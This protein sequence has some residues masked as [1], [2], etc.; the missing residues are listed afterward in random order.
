MGM[1]VLA[2]CLAG[3][4][5]AMADAVVDT[6]AEPLSNA[7]APADIPPGLQIPALPDPD[8]GEIRAALEQERPTAAPPEG[9]T[10]VVVPHH[11]LAAD[12][13]ARG[14][15]AASG[16][17]YDR[18][19][20]LAPDHFG[21][22]ASGAATVTGCMDTVLGPV[23]FDDLAQALI[24]TAAEIHRHP[25]L[26]LEHGV[27]SLLPFLAEL[28]PGTPVLPVVTSMR[29]GE[30][31]WRAI[32]DHLGPVVTARTLIVQ[33][34]DF[35]HFLS[36]TEAARV[37]RENL[38]ALA[39]GDWRAMAALDQPRHLDAMG[40]QVIMQ[41]LQAEVFQ[42][43]SAVLAN[44]TSV[45]YGGDADTVTTYIV[46]AFHP[47]PKALSAL[48]YADQSV[49]YVAGDMHLGRFMLPV[50]QSPE[51]M[52][53]VLNAA[54]AHS[55]GGPV[56]A[57]LE[58]VLAAEHIVNAPPRAHVM[59]A[60]LALPV[61]RNL[62]VVALSHA[63]NH[64][65][66]LAQDGAAMTQDLMAERGTPLIGHGEVADLGALRVLALN[67][68]PHQG[69]YVTDPQGAAPCEVEADPPLIAFVH[70]G[71]EY[72]NVPA[73]AEREMADAF[74]RCGFSAVIGAHSH[75][76]SERVELSLGQMPWVFSLGNFVFDQRA[77]RAS[78]AM[79]ELRI[80][81]RG[82]VAMRLVPIPNLFE[83]GAHQY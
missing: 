32:A 56:L 2:V 73:A 29:A 16:G 38:A 35:G 13:M 50:L 20:L 83:L 8:A 62:N 77:D 57:N 74:A 53:R 15:W 11:L 60:D 3:A 26:A 51:D 27:T 18:I 36:E 64:S 31:E 81:E 6:C 47:D 39:T 10:G 75:Q 54:R 49:L 14:L 68:V 4:A 61:L 70:W 19:V 52:A 9:I 46:S 76:A 34:T 58:G 42:A 72:T 71:A 55:A 82:T 45:D 23:V 1:L 25:N 65:H 59:P 66:D 43:Q 28:F 37:D 22:V 63:N 24:S 67:M 40:A 30:A 41:W 5:Q 44:R 69:P 33:S 80:F 7:T 21:L 78:G 12:L 79:V 17:T 48:R